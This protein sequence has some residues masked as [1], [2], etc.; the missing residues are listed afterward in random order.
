M[1]QNDDVNDVMEI[2]YQSTNCIYSEFCKLYYK[3][4]KKTLKL[5]T[6]CFN[7]IAMMK[8]IQI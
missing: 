6:T 4:Q 1:F 7:T 2:I 3:V 5:L 8:G